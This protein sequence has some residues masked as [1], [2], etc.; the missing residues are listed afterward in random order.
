MWVCGVWDLH[1]ACRVH[2]WHTTFEHGAAQP[3][4]RESESGRMA[5][6]ESLACDV[7]GRRGRGA[8]GAWSVACI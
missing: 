4:G 3:D 1:D 8:G 7:F 2:A 5:A 6:G